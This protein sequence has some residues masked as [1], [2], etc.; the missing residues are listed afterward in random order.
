M[1]RRVSRNGRELFVRP[2]RLTD[3]DRIL[4]FMVSLSPE[5]RRLFRPHPFN[6][7]DAERAVRD[8]QTGRSSR[9]VLVDPQEDE[10]V[11]YAYFSESGVGDTRVPMLGI[12]VADAYQNMGLGRL[13]MELL[14]EEARAQGKAGLQL[15]V[16]KENARAIHLYTALGFRIVGE[17]DGGKQHAMRVEFAPNTTLVERRGVFLNPMPWGLAPLTADTWSTTEWTAYL[18]FLHAAGA[19]LLM[20]FVWP[21]QYYH[22]DEA[23]TVRNGWRYGVLRNALEYARGL[24]MQTLVGFPFT[25][26]PACIWHRHPQQRATEVGF[27][28]QA[29]CWSRGRDSIQRFARFLLTALADCTDG[30]VLGIAGPA[31]C[32][33]SGCRDYARVVSDAVGHYEGWLSGRSALHIDLTGARELESRIGGAQWEALLRELP[34]ERAALVLPEDR[35]TSDHLGRAGIPILLC[36]PG[37]AGTGGSDLEALI[38]RPRL[39]QVDRLVAGNSGAAGVLGQ[40]IMPHTQFVTDFVL[41]QKLLFPARPNHEILRDLGCHFYARTSHMFEFARAIWALDAWW[42]TGRRGDLLDARDGLMA[43]PAD[44]GGWVR[45]LRDAVDLLFE[46]V[47]YLEGGERHFDALVTRVHTRMAKSPTFQ[48]CTVD[49]AWQARARAAVGQHVAGCLDRLRDHLSKLA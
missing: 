39:R 40:R 44:P 6:R 16:Y 46:L 1:I 30:F 24:G 27:Q 18:D 15:T 4:S 17:A 20:T 37:L 23:S 32:G 8:A 22:P 9:F 48:G 5:S 36:D 13:L 28:G 14:F 45:A 3:T 21:G 12:A 41:M 11:G 34:K 10:I 49:H 35:T 47:R 29:L 25:G 26:V 2:L 31:F 42:E 19:N 38:P 7:D 33:C 43:L